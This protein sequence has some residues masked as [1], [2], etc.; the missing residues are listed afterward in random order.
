MVWR[1][2]DGAVLQRLDTA[3]CISAVAVA[4]DRWAVVSMNY[5][6]VVAHPIDEGG[7]LGKG[8]VVCKNTGIIRVLH[9]HFQ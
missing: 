9:V 3:R 2:A 4:G 5:G 1:R 8:R 6:V 7:R